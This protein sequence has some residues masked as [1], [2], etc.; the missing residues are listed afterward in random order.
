[1]EGWY[2]EKQ[3]KQMEDGE[4]KK[5]IFLR[6]II[7]KVWKEKR[8]AVMSGKWSRKEKLLT[9]RNVSHSGQGADNSGG[10]ALGL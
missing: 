6:P 5:N 4:M 3:E 7:V 8:W 9:E 2:G 1:M 10:I